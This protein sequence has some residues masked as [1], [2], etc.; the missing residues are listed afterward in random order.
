[1][2]DR[3]WSRRKVT[4]G[5]LSLGIPTSLAGCSGR[6]S[7]QQPAPDVP[8]AAQF[9]PIRLPADI[10]G[11]TLVD[12]QQ[13]HRTDA[14]RVGTGAVLASPL[15]AGVPPAITAAFSPESTS[16]PEV[17]LSR[18]GN[19]SFIEGQVPFRALEDAESEDR[20]GPAVVMWA[21]W[22]AE[23]FQSQLG[24]GHQETESYQGRDLRHSE[25][26]SF[27]KIA[28]EPSV[29][30]S[31][32]FAVGATETVKAVIDVWQGDHDLLAHEEGVFSRLE[33]I[34]AT[35]PTQFVFIT[36]PASECQGQNRSQQRSDDEPETQT[37]PLD[38][39]THISGY[40]TEDEAEAEAIVVTFR[41]GAISAEA[42]KAV[43]TTAR[44][45]LLEGT[46]RSA[47]P[48]LPAEIVDAVDIAMEGE[49]EAQ[50][51]TETETQTGTTTETDTDKP[52]TNITY[53]APPE[54]APASIAEFIRTVL[55]SLESTQ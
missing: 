19:L 44:A 55:C 27:I 8:G 2:G 32:V 26:G 5:A 50:T 24:L 29:Y 54:T 16:G 31:A 33:E 11:F 30:E 17:D 18:V 4:V 37:V 48:R 9:N 41:L 10:E 43:T 13:V 20:R 12:T 7:D 25:R 34:P 23:Q 3:R 22:D 45:I 52:A 38:R 1:M 47:T 28:D 21:P 15:F 40:L 35:A 46:E 39:L 42:A 14:L 51:E 49:A 36:S 6:E 53:R